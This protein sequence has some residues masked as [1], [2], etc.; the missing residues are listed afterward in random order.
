MP[1]ERLISYPNVPVFTEEFIN[2][3][4]N[5]HVCSETLFKYGLVDNLRSTISVRLLENAEDPVFV[6]GEAMQS[7]E[8]SFSKEVGKR[9]AD[10]RATSQKIY[11]EDVN[12]CKFTLSEALHQ[13]ADYFERKEGDKE[14]GVSSVKL[15]IS[16]VPLPH[17]IVNRLRMLVPRT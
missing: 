2:A 16:G 1:I 17:G 12:W 7:P 4:D 5:D 8:D 11:H 6:L 14:I 10:G 13:T 3:F 9:I 15:P